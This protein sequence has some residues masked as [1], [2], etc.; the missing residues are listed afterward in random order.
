MIR[1]LITEKVSSV[2]MNVKLSHEMI[3]MIMI[4]MEFLTMMISVLTMQE[5]Q[6]MKLV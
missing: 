5:L 3:L 1:K 4:V 2:Q 6:V